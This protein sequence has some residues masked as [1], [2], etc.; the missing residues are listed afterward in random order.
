[1]V[2]A[3]NNDLQSSQSKTRT[4]TVVLSTLQFLF[5]FAIMAS[6]LIALVGGLGLFIVNALTHAGLVMP[7]IFVGWPFQ[8][9]L[10][11][12]LGFMGITNAKG[13]REEET[14]AYSSILYMNLLSALVLLSIGILGY[15]LAVFGVLIVLLF[16]MPSVKPLW[17]GQFKEDA[18]PRAKEFRYSLHL[19]K[20][21]PLVVVGIVIITSIV[22]IVL[23]APLLSPYGAEERVWDDGKLP[24]G[25][26]S[27]ALK[28]T[29]LD[30][31]LLSDVDVQP[32]PA[33][34]ISGF[35]MTPEMITTNYPPTINF[36]LS[37]NATTDN[38]TVYLAVYNVSVEEYGALAPAEQA[39]HRIYENQGLARMR[40]TIQLPNRTADY[41]WVFH[42]DAVEKTVPWD[43]AVSIVVYYNHW[44]PIH[45][46]GTDDVGGD[47][48]SRILWAGQTD[49]RI[50]ISVVLV[51]TVV[52]A[53]IGA[54]A[55]YYG[56][57]I[58]E[59]VM[60]VT[61]I[62]FAFPG[63]ILA[64]AIVMALGVR[65]LDNIA[66]AL[67]VTWWPVY[68]RLVRGQVLTEREKLYVEAARSVGAS[69]RRILLAHILPNTFQPLIVQATMD[70]GG[71][72]L[73]A[74]GLAFIGFGPPVGSAE[75]GLM[76]SGG[77]IYM[78]NYPW[79]AFF[80]GLMILMTALAFNLVGDGIRDILDP[81]L[82]R[83]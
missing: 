75:W 58:D 70:T 9:L 33:E 13:L 35:S 38:G 64:M 40:V 50:S 7:S 80:P 43:C 63:L 41:T 28:S 20:R 18:G 59:L 49:L 16:F 24:P 71:V 34:N 12:I 26:A 79:I 60:R 31:V 54:I 73:T 37:L 76:I 82:R 4:V 45:Y 53:I 72:L 77:Q 44:R 68:A 17:Y 11:L 2:T 55:G 74:A 21:S 25:S 78:Y 36:Y 61:D 3:D 67:M 62:F 32:Y 10:F 51:A 14:Y 42:F 65:N 29:R 66:L 15:F 46:L 69:D 81:K 1:M 47:I 6:G 30:L 52:G 8:A 23:A 19:I 48:F 57:K 39:A 22:I 83:R 56:G 27:S 5:V